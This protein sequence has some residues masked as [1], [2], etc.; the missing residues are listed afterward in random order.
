MPVFMH[1]HIHTYIHVYTIIHT[2]ILVEFVQNDGRP[3]GYAIILSLLE[4]TEYF[5][6]LSDIHKLHSDPMLR[7]PHF[8]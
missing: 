4:L 6:D 1:I 8:Q 3:S 5:S 2:E 7:R